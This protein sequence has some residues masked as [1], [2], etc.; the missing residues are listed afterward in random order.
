MTVL[1]LTDQNHALFSDDEIETLEH[2]VD[3]LRAKLFLNEQPVL[4]SPE[5]AK[6]YCQA[7]LVTREHEVFGVL[8]LDSQ[9]RVRFTEELFTGTIDAASIYP[10]E[11]VKAVCKETRWR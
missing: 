11:V 9:H 4:N 8:F 10:R 6:A 2:A 1:T 5:L 7:S 3:I